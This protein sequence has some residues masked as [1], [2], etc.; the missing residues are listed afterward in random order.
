M[1]PLLFPTYP[2]GNPSGNPVGS[3]FKTCPESDQFLT[4][5]TTPSLV[6]TT[7]IPSH[8]C[9]RRPGLPWPPCPRGPEPH[10]G[11]ENEWH[12]LSRS[13][14]RAGRTGAGGSRRALNPLLPAR[15]SPAPP[16]RPRV[17]PCTTFGARLRGPGTRCL[18]PGTR[19]ALPVR[20]DPD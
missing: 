4:T 8:G 13:Q 19:P 6:W 15:H 9:I 20:P 11:D 16:S 17:P 14:Q 2:I 12:W 7:I 3:I 1:I 10:L 5:V 18:A